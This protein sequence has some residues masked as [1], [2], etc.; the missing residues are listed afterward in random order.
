MGESQA[1]GGGLGSSGMIPWWP[2]QSLAHVA[3]PGV[4]LGSA[5]CRSWLQAQPQESTQPCIFGRVV[6]VADDG[7][8]VYVLDAALIALPEGRQDAGE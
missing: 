3:R 1:A 8:G 6:G 7:G 5:E 4:V 2:R